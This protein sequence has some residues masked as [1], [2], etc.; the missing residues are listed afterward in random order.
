[1]SATNSLNVPT[2]G[3]IA[4]KAREDLAGYYAHISA[5]DAEVGSLLATLDEAGIADDTLFVFTSDHGDMIGSQ[6]LQRKQHAYDESIRV[7]FLLRW[8]A[9]LGDKVREIHAPINAPDI[10]PTLLG[11]CDIEEPE[12]VQGADFSPCIRGE[13]PAPSDAAFLSCYVPFGEYTRAKGG[14][15]YRGLR[16]TRHTYVRTLEG[17]TLLFDNDTDPYQMDNLC[18]RPEHAAKQAD[19]DAR[20]NQKLADIG[21][22]FL[23]G[24]EYVARWEYKVDHKL[25]APYNSEL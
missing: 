17:P 3:D 1:M 24:E 12:T 21:D 18:G 19:L 13:A 10:M 20:L 5:L 7:P 23:V 15:E 8:P 16:T 25:T 4:D 9:A 14:S 11:L 22:E 6:G 2:E